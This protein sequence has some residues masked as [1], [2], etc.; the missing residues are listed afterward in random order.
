MVCIGFT[1]CESMPTVR[2]DD[3][4]DFDD[5]DGGVAAGAVLKDATEDECAEVRM[6]CLREWS[7][8]VGGDGER[9]IVATLAIVER[10][11]KTAISSR[12][13]KSTTVRVGA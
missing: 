1:V 4:D 6:L 9:D 7:G 13:V 2:S 11:L 12:N 5:S 10:C 8:A 3:F